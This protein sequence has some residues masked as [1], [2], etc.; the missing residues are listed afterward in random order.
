MSFKSGDLVLLRAD[1]LYESY[2]KP[3]EYY[4]V[5]ERYQENLVSIHS[6]QTKDTIAVFEEDLIL[7]SSV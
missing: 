7:V 3:I 1:K 5:I 6:S 2:G 4:I